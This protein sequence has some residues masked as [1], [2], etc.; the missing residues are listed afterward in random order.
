[1]RVFGRNGFAV[2]QQYVRIALWLKQHR[3]LWN[4]EKAL[5]TNELARVLR[6]KGFYSKKTSLCD[7]K[8][9]RILEIVKR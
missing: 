2:K 5:S 8:V 1:M 4:G 9:E 6:S 3:E 7:I